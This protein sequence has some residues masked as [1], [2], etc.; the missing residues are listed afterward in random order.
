MLPCSSHLNCLPKP[1]TKPLPSPGETLSESRFGT[2]PEIFPPPPC[3]SSIQTNEIK[4]LESRREICAKLFQSRQTVPDALPLLGPADVPLSLLVFYSYY[5]KIDVFIKSFFRW[6]LSHLS[7]SFHQ[8]FR[9]PN[10]YRGLFSDPQ[11]WA[12]FSSWLGSADC[13]L[14]KLWPGILAAYSALAPE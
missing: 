7:K 8:A 1:S 14:F 9:G 5:P 11:F 12:L 10:V 13:H 3:L 2:G 6:H 4:A